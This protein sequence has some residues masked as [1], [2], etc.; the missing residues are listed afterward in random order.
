MTDR[1]SEFYRELRCDACRKLICFE[2]IFDGWVKFICPRCGETTEFHFKH[3]RSAK[4]DSVK[5][6]DQ[7]NTINDA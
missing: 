5:S 1:I 6:G 4:N 2:Y 7:I 3:R